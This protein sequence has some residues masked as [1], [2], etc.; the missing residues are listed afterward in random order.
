MTAMREQRKPAGRPRNRAVTLIEV[1]LVLALMVLFAAT[2]WPLVERSLAD[3]K[4]R[5]A[6]D[7]VRAEWAQARAKAMSSGVAY[8]FCYT[9]EQQTYRLERCEDVQASD[10]S[11]LTQNSAT[12]AASN[13]NES[14]LP[15]DVVFFQGEVLDESAQ[16][17]AAQ[18]NSEST[19]VDPRTM[20]DGLS[21]APIIFYPDG[22]C[23]S[24]RLVLRNEY[25]RAIT[26]TIRGLTAISAICDIFN[27]EE[28]MP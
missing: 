9:S 15:D 14:L 10:S 2:A 3:Q 23:S 21:D 16:T 24:A 19:Q 20:E 13:A 27:V 1:M 7:M 5:D 11:S 18:Q 28:G 4:L 25:D 26:V 17:G 22:T 12:S 6:A 8:R